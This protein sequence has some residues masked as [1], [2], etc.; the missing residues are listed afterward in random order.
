MKG[1]RW[2]AFIAALGAPVPCLAN[3]TAAE[4]SIGGLQFTK[5]STVAMD[6]ED[7]LISLK[8][9]KV[10]YQF[11]NMSGA[12]VKLTVAFPLPNIDLSGGDVFSFPSNDPLN[13]VN[14]ETRIDGAGVKFAIDQRAFVGDKEVSDV[15][16]QAQLPFLPVGNRQM[17]VQDLPEATRT[18]MADQGLLVP[19][20]TNE[21][22]RPLYEPGW[23]VKTSVVR[24]Q[25]FPAGRPVVVEHSYKPSVGRNYDTVLRKELRQSSGMKQQI[26]Q[27]RRDYCITDAFLAQVDQLAGGDQ[28][29]KLKLQ[30]R[31]ISYVLKT[32]ANWSGPIKSFKLTVDKGDR[33]VLVSFCAADLKPSTPGSLT[34]EAGNFVPSRDLKILFVGQQFD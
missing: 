27:Y 1:I 19:F 10:R 11:S 22:G 29:K 30:E 12:P 34:F 20:G 32:G 23:V 7:L 24:E 16:R 15:L 14:F 18:K 13:F 26:D 17:Q 2:I 33:P 3:D 8:R 5:T 31:R 28:T 21:K 6:S 4:L 25:T 9:I